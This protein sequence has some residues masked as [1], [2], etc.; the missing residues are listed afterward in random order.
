MRLEV[1]HA[2][3]EQGT[4]SFGKILNSNK[5]EDLKGVIGLYNLCWGNT[6]VHSSPT[7]L[8]DTVT[9]MGNL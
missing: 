6:H 2:E 8:F 7:N 3:A 9:Y 4:R 1:V 5:F